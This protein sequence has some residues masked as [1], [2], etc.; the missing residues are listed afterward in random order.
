MVRR[1][2]RSS[3]LLRVQGSGHRSPFFL[4]AVDETPQRPILQLRFASSDH[5]VARVADTDTIA[6]STL[7]QDA[8]LRNAIHLTGRS[9]QDAVAALTAAPA[10]A[11][12]A[13]NRLGALAPGYA[14]DIVALT[15]RLDVAHV[16]AAGTAISSR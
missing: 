2:L 16:W 9:L 6:G 3:P 4:D 5:G 15:A 14:A 7:T 12:H 1:R 8:A 11:L 13:D 10:R